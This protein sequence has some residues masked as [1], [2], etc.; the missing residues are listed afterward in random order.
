MYASYGKKSNN[1]IDINCYN[2]DVLEMDCEGS[3][4]SILLSLTKRPR[5]IIVELHPDYFDEKYK[6]FDT[7]LIL[8]ENKGYKYQ[9]AFGHNGD[10]L[11]FQN[12]RKYYNS[13][14]NRTTLKNYRIVDKENLFFLVYPIVITFIY[15]QFIVNSN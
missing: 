5:N 4:L 6:D 13:T 1:G 8:M 15:N 7:F 14:N 10:Y 9:F 12:A 3:E 11:D 2:F